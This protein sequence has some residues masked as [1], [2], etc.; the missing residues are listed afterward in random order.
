MLPYHIAL[1]IIIT[2]LYV[3]TFIDIIFII[4]LWFGFKYLTKKLRETYRCIV[5]GSIF[6]W[7]FS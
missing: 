5:N 6:S 4:F 3:I 7:I 2:N 1:D